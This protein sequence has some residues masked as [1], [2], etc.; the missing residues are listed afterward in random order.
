MCVRVCVCECGMYIVAELISY[1]T[2]IMKGSSRRDVRKNSIYIYVAYVLEL[3]CTLYPVVL[4]K[5]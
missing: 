2:H 3:E 5:I 1:E 4:S